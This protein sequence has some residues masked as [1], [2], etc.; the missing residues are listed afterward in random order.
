MLTLP[1]F[2]PRRAWLL[3]FWTALS[4]WLGVS[5]GVFLA[6]ALGWFWLAAAPVIAAGMAALGWIWPGLVAFP[7][8]AWNKLARETARLGHFCILTVCYYVVLAP[9]ARAGSSFRLES[10]KPGE[11][12]WIKRQSS[13]GR[14]DVQKLSG[15]EF[16][17]RSWIVTYLSW[18]A[19]PRNLWTVWLIPYLLLLS[20]L[21][22]EEQKNSVPSNIYTLY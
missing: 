7:Y 2:P 9:V 11:S 19:H 8:R 17:S 15:A 12:F 16:S 6:V 18:C 1:N 21:E 20:L 13:R 10:P 4:L 14:A 3:A 5:A 22:T